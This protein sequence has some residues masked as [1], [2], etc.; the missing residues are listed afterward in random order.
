MQRSPGPDW[1]T[2]NGPLF[3][4]EVAEVVMGLVLWRVP[5]LDCVAS[6]CCFLAGGGGG[7]TLHFREDMLSGTR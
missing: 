6:C 3:S 7:G 2:G 1:G 5:L 4:I